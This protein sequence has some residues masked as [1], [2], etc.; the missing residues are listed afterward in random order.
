MWLEQVL[1]RACFAC[2]WATGSPPRPLLPPQIKYATGVAPRGNW[3]VTSP[4]HLPVIAIRP[5]PLFGVIFFQLYV[6]CSVNTA[7]KPPFYHIAPPPG[8][9]TKSLLLEEAGGRGHRRAHSCRHWAALRDGA[10]LL[11]VLRD[12]QVAWPKAVR[13]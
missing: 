1:S 10:R 9:S 12:G 13:I 3:G 4:L 8:P 6:E 7:S 11:P 2:D 5:P